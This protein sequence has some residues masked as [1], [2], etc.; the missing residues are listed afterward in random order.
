MLTVY[1]NLLLEAFVE[2]HNVLLL[3]LSQHFDFT[4]GRFLHNLVIV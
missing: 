3:E 2:R 1:D 4:H